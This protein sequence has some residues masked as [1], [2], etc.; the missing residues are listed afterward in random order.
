MIDATDTALV[1]EGGGM[2]NSYTAPAIARFI[3]ED[4][5]FGWVGGVSAGS[6]HAVN[7]A[8]RDAYRARESFTNFVGHEKFGGWVSL[9]RG[10][11]YFNAEFIYEGSNDVL[12]FDLETF[13]STRET[14]VHIEA[15]RAD[16][17]HT[18]TW[19]R[20][21]LS[22][23]EMIGQV[24]RASSTLPKVMPMGTIDGVPYVD[25]ALGVSGGLLIDAA[26][27]AGFKKFLVLATKP[28]DYVRPDNNRPTATRRLFP[29]HPAVAEALI[30]RPPRYNAS[31]EKI[32]EFE[33]QGRA[34]VFFPEHMTVD[35]SERN[36]TKLNA[37][38][39]LG[40]VQMDNE[41]DDWMEFLAG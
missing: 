22:S 15:V 30:A 26:E 27:A 3:K 4:V 24:T 28:R 29:K 25:G 36:V 20:E 8:S 32:L 18:V 37:N 35:A 9:A 12:P 40:K 34:K 11:G 10:T 13:D 19:N 7:Y 2:R 1:I 6:V 38:Y 16:T 14:Q 39:L 17:G 31:K 33:K 21:N 5:R 41:W 23:I